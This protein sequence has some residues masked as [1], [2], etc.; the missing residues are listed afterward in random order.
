M[1]WKYTS[2]SLFSNKRLSSVNNMQIVNLYLLQWWHVQH[3]LTQSCLCFTCRCMPLLGLSLNITLAQTQCN[4]CEH[5][6]YWTHSGES[7]GSRLHLKH[8]LSSKRSCWRQLPTITLCILW[9]N[10]CGSKLLS[11][12]GCLMI[13]RFACQ[14]T[15]TPQLLPSFCYL[16]FN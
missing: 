11:I 4:Y 14:Y 8:V 9:Q 2:V 3:M 15:K 6:S 5:R 10:W 7:T 13:S 16:L 1:Q 12:R